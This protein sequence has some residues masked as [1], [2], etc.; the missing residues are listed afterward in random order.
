MRSTPILHK[1]KARTWN[2]LFVLCGSGA[3]IASGS[4]ITKIVEE[5]LR[6]SYLTLAYLYQSLFL[7]L[8]CLH[9][10][11]YEHLKERVHEY[12]HSDSTRLT[13]RPVCI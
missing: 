4:S 12:L 3:F 13:Q 5:Q 7:L 11:L 8:I 10:L 1:S 9:H 6:T 2:I